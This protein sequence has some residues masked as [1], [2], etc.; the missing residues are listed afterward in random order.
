MYGTIK[1][2]GFNCNSTYCT[3]VCG[4]SCFG[5]CTINDDATAKG[6]LAGTAGGISSAYKNS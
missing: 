1:A 5:L 4:V 2:A 3:A 6:A